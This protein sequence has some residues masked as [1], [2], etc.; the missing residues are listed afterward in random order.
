MKPV[1]QRWHLLVR[2]VQNTFEDRLVPEEVVRVTMVFLPKGRGE[3]WGIGLVEVVWKVCVTA[4][5]CCLKRSVT[6]HNKCCS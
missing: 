3:Y 5:N 1:T 2:L 6:L 4:V